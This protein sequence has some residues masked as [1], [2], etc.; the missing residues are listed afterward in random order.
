MIKTNELEF[1]KNIINNLKIQYGVRFRKK[2][3]RKFIEYAQN[4]FEGMGYKTEV[5]EKIVIMFN[6]FTIPWLQSNNIPA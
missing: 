2:Q 1:N 5:Q 6:I 3:K 4:I